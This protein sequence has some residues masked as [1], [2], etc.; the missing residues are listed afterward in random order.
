MW[1]R[2]LCLDESPS[3]AG[4]RGL[5]PAGRVAR[6]EEGGR[7][8]RAE[9]RRGPGPPGGLRRLPHRPHTASGAD[10]SGYAPTASLPCSRRSAASACTAARTRPTSASRCASSR[11]SATS[12]TGR[13]AC[14]ATASPFVTSWARARSPRRRCCPRSPSRRSTRRRRPTSSARWR[15]ARPP[16]SAP[17]ST[18]PRSSRARRAPCSEPASSASARAPAAASRG[19]SGS[20]APTGPRIAWRWPAPRGATDT[21]VGGEDAV[22]QILEMTD[23]FGADYTFEATGS[24]AAMRQA[25]ESARMGWGCARSPA[26]PAAARFRG[27]SA[28]PDHRPAHRRRIV[29][30]R[31]GPATA[32]PSSPAPTSRARSTSSRSSH[33]PCRSTTSTRRSRL[34]SARRASGRS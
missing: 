1:A 2:Q 27:H 18:S 32:S 25:V 3:R 9:G 29:R 33:A 23:G 4:A 11:A 24:V 8:R 21:F 5:S 19:R 22:Q 13:R 34:W 31:Q 10:P 14:R 17:R 16:A 20:S 7:S 15:A 30:W 28:L 6:R 12:R 26:S